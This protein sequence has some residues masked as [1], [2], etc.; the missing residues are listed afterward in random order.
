MAEKLNMNMWE[1]L[2]NQIPKEHH[3][4]LNKLIEL[5]KRNGAA[6]VLELVRDLGNIPVNQVEDYGIHH[7]NDLDGG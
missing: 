5:A 7:S 6:Q 1:G 3:K 4:T 2:Y